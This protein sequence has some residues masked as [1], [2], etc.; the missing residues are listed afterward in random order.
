MKL[1][2]IYIIL[3]TK[4][5]KKRVICTST[6]PSSKCLVLA[7]MLYSSSKKLQFILADEISRET[8][9]KH[10]KIHELSTIFGGLACKYTFLQ[11]LES[12]PSNR[13]TDKTQ[14][15]GSA[16]ICKLQCRSAPGTQ[17]IP[18]LILDTRILRSR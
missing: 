18:Q 2:I 8:S 16:L 1:L 5:C 4:E 14:E 15:T 17:H 6:A 7:E 13:S 12:H 11:K 3:Q 10:S 9:V